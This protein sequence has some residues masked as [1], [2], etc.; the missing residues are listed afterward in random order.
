MN[1]RYCIPILV[2]AFILVFALGLTVSAAPKLAMVTGRVS[3]PGYASWPTA[4]GAVTLT[5]CKTGYT[6][7]VTPQ[8]DTFTVPWPVGKCSIRLRAGNTLAVVRAVKVK[9]KGAV[10]NFGTLVPGDVNGDNISDVYDWWALEPSINHGAPC[11]LCDV[12]YDGQVTEDDLFAMLRQ[13]IT[14]GETCP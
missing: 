11:A 10:V 4:A 3:V 7:S 2:C 13:G 6:V 1:R 5:D 14:S 9:G 8:G 12:N